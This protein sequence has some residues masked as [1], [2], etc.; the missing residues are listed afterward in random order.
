MDTC[1][2]QIS[3]RSRFLVGLFTGRARDCRGRRRPWPPPQGG[4]PWCAPAPGDSVRRGIGRRQHGPITG[5]VGDYR[6][7]RRPWPP[8]SQ[9]GGPWCASAPGESVRRGTGTPAVDSDKPDPAHGGRDGNGGAT[10]TPR[11]VRNHTPR[12]ALPPDHSPPESTVLWQGRDGR[13]ICARTSVRAHMEPPCRPSA[14]HAAVR[15]RTPPT[16]CTP[17]TASRPPGTTQAPACRRPPARAPG[18][19]HCPSSCT[20]LAARTR[21]W[22]AVG[23]GVLPFVSLGTS[24]E[25]DQASQV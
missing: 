14:G 19:R 4:G 16:A 10:A 8:P 7:R 9:G 12:T 3:G 15:I 25:E 1:S 13:P 11:S 6:G 18:L 24:E 20:P 17:L 2:E 21:S 23:A 22:S 5:R